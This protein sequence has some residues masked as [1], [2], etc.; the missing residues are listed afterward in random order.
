MTEQKKNAQVLNGINEDISEL[1]SL[2]TLRKR[3]VS[4]SEIVSK[5]A[6]AFRLANGST[7][8]ILRNDS[9]DFYTLITPTGQ[10]LDGSWNTL[11]PL[12]IN[13]ASGRVS[14]RNGVDISGGALV[15]HDAGISAMTT[16]PAS[17]IDGQTYGAPE[18]Q[19]HFTSGNV[20]TTMKMST[21]FA[22]GKEEMG[23]ISY[24]DSEG[25]CNEMKLRKGGGLDIGGSFIS[26][27]SHWGV[28]KCS[29]AVSENATSAWNYG[30]VL[31]GRAHEHNVGFSHYEQFNSHTAAV[32]SVNEDNVKVN[33][34]FHFRSNGIGYAN[35]GWQTFSDRR[36]KDDIREIDRPLEKLLTLKPYTYYKNGD[37]FRSASIM[38]QDLLA[39]LPEGVTNTG[40]FI[41]RDGVEVD[42]CLAVS[43]EAVIGLLVGAV[44]ELHKKLHEQEQRLSAVED[45]VKSLHENIPTSKIKTKNEN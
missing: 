2:S 40:T 37:S 39:V 4:D 19:T 1:K 26:S 41:R 15:S 43:N 44:S 25:V 27:S 18:I 42:N 9:K 10:A 28:M 12:T 16:G 5:S 3:V 32:I 20:T 36:I 35:N 14:L 21:R 24:R 30:M 45:I 31:Y 6:S 17:L 38:A 13:L 23:L 7:G 33:I 29:D 22:A 11:R 8:V 34:G